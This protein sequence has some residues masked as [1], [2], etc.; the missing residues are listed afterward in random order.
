M[1]L[2]AS[3]AHADEAM[4]AEWNQTLFA[5]VNASLAN[6]LAALPRHLNLLEMPAGASREPSARLTEIRCSK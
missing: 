4:R 6:L 2:T 3:S 1:P 5:C